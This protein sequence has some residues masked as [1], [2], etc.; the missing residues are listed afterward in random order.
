M[1]R[2]IRSP[3]VRAL[4]GRLLQLLLVLYGVRWILGQALDAQGGK[5]IWLFSQDDRHRF[6]AMSMLTGTL[7]LHN[8]LTYLGGDEQAYGGASYTNW[9]FGVPAM[10][11][12]FQA[13]APWLARHWTSHAKQFAAG[14][15]PDRA[16]YFAYVMLLVPVLWLALD[17]TLAGGA[18]SRARW[19]PRT[20]AAGAATAL[21]FNLTLFPLVSS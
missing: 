9:G 17:R 13:V 7:R 14:F 19:L 10:Q 6:T 18:K 8:G 20:L 4:A 1:L 11:L 5:T 21:V 12:P 2:S 3:R 15:F 16:I